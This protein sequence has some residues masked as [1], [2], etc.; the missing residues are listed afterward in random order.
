MK[1]KD[2]QYYNKL[3]ESFFTLMKLT[4]KL[5]FLPISDVKTVIKLS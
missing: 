5:D 1:Y 3:I 2:S 4:E